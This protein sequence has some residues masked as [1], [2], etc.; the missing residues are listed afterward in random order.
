MAQEIDVLSHLPP[1]DQSAL[2]PEASTARAASAPVRPCAH[3]FPKELFMLVVGTLVAL[4]QVAAAQPAAQRAPRDE[5]SASGQCVAVLVTSPEAVSS[6]SQVFSATKILD[7]ELSAMLRSRLQGD[8]TLEMKVYT[9]KGHLYQVLTVPFS[10]STPGRSGAAR[11]RL[12]E[13]YPQPLAEQAMTPVSHQ[14]AR[15]YQVSARLPVA[16]TSI[17]T[18]SLYGRWRVDAHLDGKLKACSS[19]SFTIQ[20]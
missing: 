6:K 3:P 1:F 7:L 10:A 15:R 5:P 8:H 11:T 18:S 12:V 20:P 13:G 9:P 17:M 4:A 16:G 14:G 19:R 2:K